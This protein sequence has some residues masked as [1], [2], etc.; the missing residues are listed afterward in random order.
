M[1]ELD[2]SSNKAEDSK[3]LT[4]R[5][6]ELK[7]DSEKKRDEWEVISTCI[8]DRKFRSYHDGFVTFS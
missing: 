1:Q 5:K 2:Q 6:V 4:K 7:D 3:N 8:Y